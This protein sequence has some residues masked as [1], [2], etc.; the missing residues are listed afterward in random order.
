MRRRQPAVADTNA[1]RFEAPKTE[2]VLSSRRRKHRRCEREVQVGSH[3][4]RF[5]LEARPRRVVNQYGVPRQQRG[6]SRQ[7][8]P[9]EPC[10]T[11]LRSLGTEERRPRR[12]ISW[13]PTGWV[14][15]RWAP[16]DQRHAALSHQR[17]RNGVPAAVS[18]T[19]PS[20]RRG[21]LPSRPPA[22]GDTGTPSGPVACGGVVVELL[23]VLGPIQRGSL[24]ASRHHTAAA[25]TLSFSRRDP[26]IHIR[27][28][29]VAQ[30]FC[31]SVRLSS[32]VNLDLPLEAA[33]PRSLDLF[34]LFPRPQEG[35]FPQPL[36][37]PGA[38]SP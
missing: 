12:S 9:S 4:A 36:G 35:A 16:L 26:S 28:S 7:R 8:P 3:R 2:A 10:S 18:P 30:D 14:R 32:G 6:T 21:G 15:P 13:P 25:P 22:S 37:E 11:Y 23:P 33:K 20:L 27:V 38:S 29:P 31:G 17:Q 34:L 24:P 1:V 19:E 5:N